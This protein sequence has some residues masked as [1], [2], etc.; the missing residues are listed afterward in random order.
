MKYITFLSIYLLTLSQIYCQYP[1]KQAE[2]S[3]ANIGGENYSVIKLSNFN[4]KLKAKYFAAKDQNNNSVYKRYLGWQMNKNVICY[5]S[6]TYMDNYNIDL[7]K[8]VGL[9]IDQGRIVNRGLILNKFD[10]LVIAYP[11]G[12]ITVH[13]LKSK[14]MQIDKGDGKMTN[15]NLSNNFERIQFMNWA[16]EQEVTVFQTHLFCYK[17][18]FFSNIDNSKT[19]GRR[20]LAAGTNSDGEFKQYIIN[21]SSANTLLDASRKAINYLKSFE[22]LSEID[23][24][25][26]LDPGAQDVFGAYNSAGQRVIKSGF[27]GTLDISKSLNLIVYY[28]D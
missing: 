16:Q 23:F 19:A 12:R 4:K 28:V 22:E 15:Y 2:F 21:L 1:S 20:F 6:G 10:G 3:T 24:L 27:Q 8:P 5:S 14:T 7:A 25:I 9:C 13:N 17:N 11:S 26:N 18:Q